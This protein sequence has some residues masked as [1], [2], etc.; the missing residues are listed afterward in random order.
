MELVVGRIS[1]TKGVETAKRKMWLEIASDG[2]K[3]KMLR[4]RTRQDQ[5]YKIKKK[6]KI[7]R[8]RPRPRPDVQDEDQDQDQLSNSKNA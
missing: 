8:P 4:P 2:N 7:V 5:D 3:T 6:T 1:C